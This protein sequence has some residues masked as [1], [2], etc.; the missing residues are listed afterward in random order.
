LLRK[1]L[2]TWVQGLITIA[3]LWMMALL[4]KVVVRF[5]VRVKSMRLPMLVKE[6]TS[7]GLNLARLGLD[8]K[9]D[10]KDANTVLP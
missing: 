10:C 6:V 9:I 3:R 7:I 5:K 4:S 2:L 8:L 1:P